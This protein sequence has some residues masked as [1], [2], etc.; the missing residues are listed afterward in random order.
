M[1]ERMGGGR[2][3]EVV[4]ADER[5]AAPVPVVEAIRS[6]D[7][8]RRPRAGE[9]R[10]DPFEPRDRRA[11]VGVHVGDDV[12]ARRKPRRFAR[13]DQPFRR[14]LEHANPR[15]RARHLARRVGAGVVDDQDLVGRPRL[16]AQRIEA[17]RQETAFV[18]RADDRGNRQRH[19]VVLITSAG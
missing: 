1:Y 5:A 17:T 19:A 6:G 16:R 9:L 8:Q 3:D 12:G 2:D 18:I 11:A 7:R 4:G 13:D 15:N 10:F 14:F